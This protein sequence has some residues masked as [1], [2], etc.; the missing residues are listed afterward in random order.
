MA[1]L[2]GENDRYLVL[3]E[4][5]SVLSQQ[6]LV[7]LLDR[8]WQVFV[9]ELDGTLEVGPTARLV[10]PPCSGTA[11]GATSWLAIPPP[12]PH[13]SEN[14]ANQEDRGSGRE[15]ALRI[16]LESLLPAWYSCLLLWKSGY[17]LPECSDDILF[18]Q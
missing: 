6:Q 1:P 14:M 17:K 3:Q 15:A 11:N 16:R 9:E 4:S 18:F 13:R 12:P 5:H 10:N 2:R 8:Q 7:G